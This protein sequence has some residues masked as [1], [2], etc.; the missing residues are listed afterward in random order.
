VEDFFFLPTRYHRVRRVQSWRYSLAFNRCLFVE[1]KNNSRTR[2]V[3]AIAKDMQVRAS[4]K[5]RLPIT[6][7]EFPPNAC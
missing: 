4:A 3:S 6:A 2:P 7:A 5:L 1:L